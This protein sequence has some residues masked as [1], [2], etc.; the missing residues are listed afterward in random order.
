MPILKNRCEAI[1]AYTNVTFRKF[2]KVFSDFH[3]SLIAKISDLP[4][5]N[6]EDN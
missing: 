2:I 4:G 1:F 5:Q 3:L 6:L